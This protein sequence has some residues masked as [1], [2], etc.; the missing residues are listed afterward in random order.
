MS[1]RVKGKILIVEENNKQQEKGSLVEDREL[2]SKL[3]KSPEGRILVTGVVMA[4]LYIAGVALSSLWDPETAQ[5]I[6]GMTATH[7]LF[8]RAAGMSFGYSLGLG[9]GSVVP[10]NMLI[11]TVMVLLFFPLFVFSWRR[12][13]IIQSLKDIMDRLH[14]AADTHRD[15]IHRYG[16]IGLMAFVW[17]PFWMTGPLVGCILGF[18]IGLRPW[19]NLTIVLAGTYLAIASWAVLLREIHDRVAAFSPYAPVILLAI[20][21]VIV[22]SAHLLSRGKKKER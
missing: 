20:V 16:I 14:E 11:E 5:V 12:L 3:L 13:L 19:L 9:H 15:S 6:V 7:I 18:F 22:F 2:R 17:F 1:A 8:G 4:V 21:I 10:V